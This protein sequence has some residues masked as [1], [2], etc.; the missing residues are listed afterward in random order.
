MGLGENSTSGKLLSLG[1]FLFSFLFFLLLALF[2]LFSATRAEAKAKS[3]NLFR[4]YRPEL[5]CFSA[6]RASVFWVDARYL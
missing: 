6:E 4:R 1:E 5:L 2:L 3:S